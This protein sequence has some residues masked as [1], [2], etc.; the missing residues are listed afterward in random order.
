MCVISAT[1]I[2]IIAVVTVTVTGISAMAFIDLEEEPTPQQR[3]SQSLGTTTSGITE[4]VNVG[5]MLPSTG[6]L[7]SHGQDN[8]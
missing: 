7:S 8:S 4:T 3:T 2:A 5:V 1:T 6:D